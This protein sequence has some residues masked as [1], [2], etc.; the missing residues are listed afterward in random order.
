MQ[1]TQ[2]NVDSLNAILKLKVKKEDYE[3]KILKSL[4]EYRK[5]V[6]L[7]GFRRGQVPLGVV[8]KMYGNHILAETVNEMLNELVNNYII[9]NKLDVLGNPLPKKDQKF[10]IEINDLKDFDFEYEIGLAPE[11]D[12]D[13]FKKKPTLNKDVIDITAKMIDEEMDRVRKR[14]GNVEEVLGK[15]EKD[16]ML[17]LQFDEIDSNDTLVENGISHNAPIALDMI[18]DQKIQKK[19]KGLKK[20]ENFLIKDLEKTFEKTADELAKQILNLDLTPET[21]PGVQASL[22]D[23]KRV[24]PAE[25]TED[26]LKTVYGEGSDVKDEAGM[27][28]HIEKEIKVYFEKQE[29][30]RLYNK[31]AETLIEKTAMSFPDDFLKRWIKLTNE[32]PISEEQ[33]DKEYPAFAKNLKWSLIVKKVSKENGVDVSMEE[34]KARTA[35][36]VRQQMASYGIPDM[37]QEEMEKFV[38]NMMAKKDHSSQ[39]RET[40]LEEKLFEFFKGQIKTKDKKV[41]LEE[42]YKQ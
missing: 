11:F 42:F 37:P 30:S 2:E 32:N 28:S 12:L 19:V 26:F 40:L 23:V 41:S 17:T 20:G 14:Y 27:R 22:V 21:L 13:F 10:D 25:I 5:K 9:E 31:L 33:I 24:H 29:D 39:T 8:K 36:Q 38:Q 15:M 6:D 7:K 1:I 18:K 34:V 35:D 3:P 16:D 4:N